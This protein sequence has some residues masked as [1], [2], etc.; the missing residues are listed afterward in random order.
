MRD[1]LA[2]FGAGAGMLGGIQVHEPPTHTHMKAPTHPQTH[3]YKYNLHACTLTGTPCFSTST[4]WPPGSRDSSPP[5]GTVQ[6]HLV[7]SHSVCCLVKPCD[8]HVVR[9]GGVMK[10]RTY[11]PDDQ[12]S[13]LVH[14]EKIILCRKYYGVAGPVKHLCCERREQDIGQSSR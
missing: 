11:F 3:V 7:F 9:V 5:Q 1:A 8:R 13:L 2:G 12:L 6:T 10:V 14:E 4:R